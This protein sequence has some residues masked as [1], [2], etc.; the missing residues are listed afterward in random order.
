MRESQVRLKNE[1]LLNNGTYQEEPVQQDTQDNEV[2]GENNKEVDPDD[3]TVDGNDNN[4]EEEASPEADTTEEPR[5]GKRI[6]PPYPTKGEMTQA[7]RNNHR[8][9]EKEK[10]K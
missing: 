6:K 5:V 4:D 3:E 2:E 9:K 1:E 10:Q 8:C 7:S